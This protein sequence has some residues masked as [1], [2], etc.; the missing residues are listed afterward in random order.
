MAMRVFVAGASGATGRV[1]VEE[2]TRAGLDLVVHVRPQSVERTPLGKDPRAAVFELDDHQ[3]LAR[4]LA[5][6]DAAVSFVGTM[7]KRFGAGDTYASSDVGTTRHLMEGATSAQVPRLLLLSSYGAGAPRG[8]YLAAKAESEALLRASTLKWTVFRPSV[9]VTPPGTPEGAHGAR[10]A[11]PGMGPFFA[12]V[13]ALPGLRGVA[14]DLKPMPLDVLARAFVA[15][16][17]TPADQLHGRALE[18]RDIWPLGS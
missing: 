13:G 14:D 8:A 10:R 4:A 3:A 5:G 6:C 15:V 18:G 12:V 1:F 9:L 17:R 2:A 11:P 7:K 16:L